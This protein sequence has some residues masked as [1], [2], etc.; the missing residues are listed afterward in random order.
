MAHMGRTDS[1]AHEFQREI[2]SE[3]A[4]TMFEALT[5]GNK[6]KT[7]LHLAIDKDQLWYREVES[8][9]EMFYTQ[10]ISLVF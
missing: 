10:F 1:D 4:R 7:P 3:H 2:S 6:G 9:L 5:L 8:L